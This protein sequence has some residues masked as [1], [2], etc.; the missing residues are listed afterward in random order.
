MN[1]IKTVRREVFAMVLTLD[2]EFANQLVHRREITKDYADYYDAY[3]VILEAVWHEPEKASAILADLA[4]YAD[5]ALREDRDVLAQAAGAYDNAFKVILRELIA[6]IT[7]EY[8]AVGEQPGS[9]HEEA[10]ALIR[11]IVSS[12]VDS[13]R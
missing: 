9:S 4:D 5:D 2:D 7:R 3:G 10:L 11:R 8:Q 1:Y 6:R 12:E 13:D